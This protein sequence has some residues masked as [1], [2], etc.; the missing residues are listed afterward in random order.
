M[1]TH[2]LPLTLATAAFMAVGITAAWAPGSI[3]LS[4]VMDQLKD[5][6]KLIDEIDAELKTQDLNPDNIVCIGC[7]F[8]NQWVN[9]GGARAIPYNCTVGNRTLDIDGEL[10]L[11]D[12]AG[13]DLDMDDTTAPEQATE[14]KQLNLTWKWS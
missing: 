7:R 4:E 6:Q 14:Y 2:A 12:A 11:Y 5:N 8:G 3:P 10:H 9:L 13:K 1:L